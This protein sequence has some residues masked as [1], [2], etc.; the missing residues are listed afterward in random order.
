[1]AG[2]VLRGRHETPDEPTGHRI[3]VEEVVLDLFVRPQPLQLDDSAARRRAVRGV[4]ADARGGDLRRLRLVQIS[5]AVEFWL[6]RI[7]ERLG[8]WRRIPSC[9]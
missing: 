8:R 3:R 9:K 6:H 5:S 2:L 4:P 7:G 1:M